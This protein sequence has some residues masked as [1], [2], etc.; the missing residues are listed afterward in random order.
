MKSIRHPPWC[1][2][3]ASPRSQA[4][5]KSK[6]KCTGCPAPSRRSQSERSCSVTTQ[7]CIRSARTSNIL[8]IVV[9]S[10]DISD[11]RCRSYIKT[12]DFPPP[13]RGPTSN[14]GRL[15]RLSSRS[16]SC[17]S[18][19]LSPPN[20]PLR[21]E[22]QRRRLIFYGPSVNPAHFTTSPPRPRNAY[23]T[24]SH[25]TPVHELS[26][27]S[28]TITCLNITDNRGLNGSKSETE[29]KLWYAGAKIQI[30]NIKFC[31]RS[32]STN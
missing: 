2:V 28:A 30:V 14:N 1:D 6:E 12:I 21:A 8:K 11:M 13:Q 20:A 3:V 4:R 24:R 29:D 9:K 15:A 10:Q 7:G 27:T 26:S 16:P 19:P 25:L 22:S 31:R 23:D 17:P 5:R 18:C 32:M